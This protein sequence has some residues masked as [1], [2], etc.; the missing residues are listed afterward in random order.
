VSHIGA[1]SPH[2][3]AEKFEDPVANPQIE[4][5]VSISNRFHRILTACEA[6]ADAAT[7]F[8]AVIAG[9]GAYHFLHLG[10]RLEYSTHKIGLIALGLAVVYVIL[11]D[12][13]GA[14]RPGNSLLRIRETERT[15][16]VSLQSFFLILPLTF[17]TGNTFSRW[18]IMIALFFVPMLQVAEKQILFAVVRKL[19]SRGIGVHRVLIYGAGSS[20]QRVFSALVRSPQLGLIPVAL[21]DDNPQLEGE[22]I[23]E[24]AYRREHSIKVMSKRVSKELLNELKCDFLMVA[25]PSLPPERFEEAVLIARAAQ[26][27]LAFVPRQA[28]R[29][30][31][32]TEYA[33]VDGIMLNVVGLPPSDWLYEYAKRLLDVFAALTLIVMLAP[34]WLTLLF[35]VKI[36]SPGP[37]FFRQKRVGRK[38]VLFEFIKIR[39]M[40]VDAPKYD[41]SPKQS[42]DPRITRIGRFL[43]RTSLDELAQLINV[44][45]GEMSLVGP[46]PEM[47]FIVRQYDARQRQRLQVA[48]GITGLWQLSADRAYLIHE[49][50][51]YDLY[52]IRHRSFFMDFAILLH[53]V[54]FAMRGV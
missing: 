18:V 45:K 2:S 50:I 21:V 33:D 34:L 44:L 8:V 23:F 36:D 43:R 32:W 25:I 17:F 31:Y 15:L 40:Y 12:R 54:V 30:G 10:K 4:R 14:Y 22:E 11:L 39:T 16:R 29:A 9:Y 37:V 42:L 51:H 26:A 49:N 19:R 7:V 27:R 41:Y 24:S 3:F 1:E 46:R 48:P 28:V 13:D 6:A 47:P 5:P 38:G 52:Y 53:T 20:G 35:L